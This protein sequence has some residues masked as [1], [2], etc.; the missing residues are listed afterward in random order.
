MFCLFLSVSPFPYFFIDYILF[1]CSCSKFPVFFLF[2][3]ALFCLCFASCLFLSSVS[4]TVYPLSRSFP[5]VNCPQP[6]LCLWVSLLFAVTVSST[7][8]NL[9]VL[10]QQNLS[11]SQPNCEARVEKSPMPD[12]SVLLSVKSYLGS[13]LMERLTDSK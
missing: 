3:S 1:S 13:V 8:D 11:S 6:C 4:Y 9:I 7:T 2:R 12:I 5:H 10:P